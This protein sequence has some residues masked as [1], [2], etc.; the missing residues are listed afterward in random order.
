MTMTQLSTVIFWL[1]PNNWMYRVYDKAIAETRTTNDIVAEGTAKTHTEVTRLAN[2][3]RNEYS[4]Y[5]S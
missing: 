2:Q 1:S 5:H 4:K 3:A